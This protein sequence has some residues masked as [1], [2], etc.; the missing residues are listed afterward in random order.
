MKL[1]LTSSALPFAFSAAFAL[2]AFT[3]C[4]ISEPG[5][6]G[7]PGA[8]DEPAAPYVAPSAE[9]AEA[10]VQRIDCGAGELA[11]E[12]VKSGAS[13]A[14]PGGL[15]KLG[16]SENGEKAELGVASLPARY[17]F[18]ALQLNLCNSGF[19]GCYE[20][21]TSVPEGASVIQRTAPDVVTLNEICQSD[22]VALHSTLSA[23][24]SGGTVVWAFKAAGNRSTGGPYKCK[25]GQDYGIG[26]IA[27]IP[28]SY[29]GYQITSG[30]YPAQDSGSNEQRAWLC[31]YATGNYYACTTHLA[32]V[33]SVALSQCTYLMSTAIPAART[34]GGAYKPTI[35]GGDLNLR[36]GG[37]PN[38]Q[39]CVPSGT[40]RK[41]DGS[42]QHFIATS[43]LTFNST[44]SIGMSHTDHPAWFMKT[45]AP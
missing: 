40:Y 13:A 15:T 26:V 9:A 25:N 3:G 16:Q 39:S 20:N 8:A 11:G 38:A 19:A 24:Y 32:T 4:A 12:C 2:A 14:Q 18:W 45:T 37:S 35:M 44:Q 10:A 33:G 22:V 7:E 36:Y 30:L 17:P 21:G 34:A 42:V 1:H 28:S 6:P 43:D 23:V 41:G 27:H 31:L 29:Q 5:E